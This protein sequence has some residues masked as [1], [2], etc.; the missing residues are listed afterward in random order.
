[1]ELNYDFILFHSI[2]YYA[3]YCTMLS[4]ELGRIWTCLYHKNQSKP[5]THKQTIIF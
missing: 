1:M 4:T 3:E 2:L 5:T